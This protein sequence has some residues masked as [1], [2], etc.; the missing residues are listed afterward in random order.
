MLLQ[1]FPEIESSI[2]TPQSTLN[3]SS[4]YETKHSVFSI[5]IRWLPQRRDHLPVEAQLG[6][7]GGHP[8][9]EALP[10]RLYRTKKYNWGGEDY[11]R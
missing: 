7:G 1:F 8:L 4:D 10:V 3:P 2:F 9:L 6:G 5:A 11:F